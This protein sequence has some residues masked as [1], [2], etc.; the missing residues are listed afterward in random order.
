MKC[1]PETGVCLVADASVPKRTVDKKLAVHYIGDPMCSWCWGIS[2][3]LKATE[4]FCADE[5]IPFSVNVGGLRV[6]GG[7]P[8]NTQFKDFLRHEWQHI[9]QVS[10]QPFGY[11]LLE[12]DEF[13][14]DTEPAC[15]AVVSVQLLQERDRLP[16]GVVLEF[17]SAVQQHFY[18]DGADPRDVDFYQGPCARVGI[19][20]AAFKQL[21]RSETAQHAVQRAFE[22][23]RQWG[24]NS[25]PTLLLEV[26]GEHIVLAK[27][28]TTDEQVLTAL[29]RRLT[30]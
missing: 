5:N 26:D 3:A 15:R 9:S 4:A 16:L 28:Y 14:Y 19:D 13:N 1:D 18:V 12:R 21:F 22:Q 30:A 11:T 23:R 17:F 27:G 8:W 20:F 24:V 6:G 29:Q 25:F 7:D 10:G 2:S